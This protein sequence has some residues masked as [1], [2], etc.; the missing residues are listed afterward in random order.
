[1]KKIN[2]H[3]FFRTPYNLVFFFSR[4][5]MFIFD[6]LLN[7]SVVLH[8]NLSNIYPYLFIHPDTLVCTGS[9]S[10]KKTT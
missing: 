1:M 4:N 10:R 9:S 2:Q 8:F 5:K 7:K 3:P 6:S